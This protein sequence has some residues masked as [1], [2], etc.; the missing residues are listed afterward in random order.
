MNIPKIKKIADKVIDKIGAEMV[1]SYQDGVNRVDPNKVIDK[2]YKGLK[3]PQ[4]DKELLDV[5]I[6]LRMD[7][8][9]T[10]MRMVVTDVVQT[11]LEPIKSDIA[12]IKKVVGCNGE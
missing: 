5:I 10:N 7:S 12:R 11:E 4:D 3:L 9:V 6:R 8:S 1:S 2:L